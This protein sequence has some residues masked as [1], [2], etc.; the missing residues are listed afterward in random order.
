MWIVG[1]LVY[2]LPLSVH[3]LNKLLA[4]LRKRKEIWVP[5]GHHIHH[6]SVPE[7]LVQ[8]SK[9]I[10]NGTNLFPFSLSPLFLF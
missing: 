3:Q 6:V 8:L 7:H 10:L 5:G 1:G 4:I 9:T 2:F